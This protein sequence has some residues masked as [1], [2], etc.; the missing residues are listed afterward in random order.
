MRLI[1]GC[2]LYTRNYGI[3]ASLDLNIRYA[4]TQLGLDFFFLF[5]VTVKKKIWYVGRKKFFFWFFWF[6]SV[7]YACFMMIGSRE[8]WKNIKVG[9]FL[10]KNLLG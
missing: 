7:F 2:V 6:K 5:P 1:Y 4:K 9:I 3:G 8:G 10:N